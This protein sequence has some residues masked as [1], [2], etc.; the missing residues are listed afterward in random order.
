MRNLELPA[1][2]TPSAE[3]AAL[4]FG[5]WMTII[6]PLMGDLSA[7]SKEFWELIQEEVSVKYSEWLV[8][9]AAQPHGSSFGS[10]SA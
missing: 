3:N 8:V 6:T 5:D 7:S 4:L 10:L 9:T 1:L 2:P